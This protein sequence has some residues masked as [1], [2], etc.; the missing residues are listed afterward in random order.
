MKINKLRTGLITALVATLVISPITIARAAD[1][2]TLGR[3]CSAEGISTG[4][5]TDN[6][7]K[8]GNITTSSSSSDKNDN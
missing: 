6:D 3:S 2:P 1:T 5:S 8:S 7:N 4:T